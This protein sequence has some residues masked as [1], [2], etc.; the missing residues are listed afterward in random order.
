MV[1]SSSSSPQSYQSK[2]PNPII[3]FKKK[4]KPYL[5]LPSPKKKPS[6]QHIM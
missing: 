2:N 6:P 4:F 1:F 5:F 3:F